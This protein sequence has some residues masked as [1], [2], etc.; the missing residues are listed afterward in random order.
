MT[1]VKAMK[2]MTS[3]PQIDSLLNKLE[4]LPTPV[5]ITSF[6]EFEHYH[7]LLSQTKKTDPTASEL[8]GDVV[9]VKKF[10]QQTWLKCVGQ[11]LTEEEA[12]GIDGWSS[13]LNL[14]EEKTIIRRHMFNKIC[15][16][17]QHAPV[18]RPIAP[19]VVIDPS[20]SNPSPEHFDAWMTALLGTDDPAKV[21]ELAAA[22]HDIMWRRWLIRDDVGL[23]LTFLKV[24]AEYVRRGLIRRES[25]S[26]PGCDLT[27]DYC[28]ACC[29]EECDGCSDLLCAEHCCDDGNACPIHSW[30]DH[31]YRM[32]PE[33][34][35]QLKEAQ[36]DRLTNDKIVRELRAEIVELKAQMK[37]RLK[38]P[39]PAVAAV[40]VKT[41]PATPQTTEIVVEV[42][43]RPMKAKHQRTTEI[44]EDDV[45]AE[46]KEDVDEEKEDD[47]EEEEE[48]EDD[49]DD[50]EEEGDDE[51]EE[52]D[53]GS[54]SDGSVEFGKASSI[55]RHRHIQ[56]EEEDEDDDYYVEDKK[57]DDHDGEVDVETP[58]TRKRA[59]DDDGDAPST[60]RS[61][62]AAPPQATGKLWQQLQRGDR[63][64]IIGNK[65]CH[66]VQQP[67]TGHR[68]MFRLRNIDEDRDVTEEAP[69]VIPF[70]IKLSSG[71]KIGDKV[72]VEGNRRFDRM[73]VFI[74]TSVP[75]PPDCTFV[76]REE[77]GSSVWRAD[78]VHIVP[79]DFDNKYK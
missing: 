3:S 42:K 50:E 44:A 13:D 17:R 71:V 31:V 37:D 52:D 75:S 32:W 59:N 8:L 67:P 79:L 53:T 24:A 48:E 38:K 58:R 4:S 33:S 26:R 51:E 73:E 43:T 29:G 21:S 20:S 28:S 12:R 11:H 56:S 1:T 15:Q 68:E 27:K 22:K 76:I 23:P 9:K 54:T 49:V 63:A 35:Q 65:C 39:G 18:V 34:Q 16:H 41:Q 47:D 5:L 61:R 62:V 10:M 66:V 72:R 78:E 57:D 30:H 77:S 70:H 64:R 69:F 25:T 74:V 45:D 46:E 40:A 7:R 60:K 55:P 2:S 6:E 14:K 36:D 19:P